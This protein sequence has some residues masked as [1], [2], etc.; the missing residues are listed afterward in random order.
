MITIMIIYREKEI[1]ATKKTWLIFWKRNCKDFKVVSF[2]KS[3]KKCFSLFLKS[4][5]LPLSML[6]L[7]CYC[8]YN[9]YYYYEFLVPFCFIP[10]IFYLFCLHF[11]VRKSLFSSFIPLDKFKTV[12]SR[13][14]RVEFLIF[15]DDLPV[16]IIW[17]RLVL[18]VVAYFLN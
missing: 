15:R 12:V 3:G 13:F 9:H 1:N 7:F 11:F 2:Q 4:F 5:L 16:R 17:K 14:S 8:H 6:F 18:F 10:Q